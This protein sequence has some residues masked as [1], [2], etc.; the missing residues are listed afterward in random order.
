MRINGGIIGEPTLHA[1]ERARDRYDFAL[2]DIAHAR[3]VMD[4]LNKS[5]GAEKLGSQDYRLSVWY[6][7]TPG[8][9]ANAVFDSITNRIVTLLPRDAK[10]A[11]GVKLR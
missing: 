6:L 10:Y 2:T 4:I 1:Q 9:P 8:G 5:N 11:K 7:H 3:L